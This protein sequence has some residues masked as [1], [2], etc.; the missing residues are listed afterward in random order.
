MASL[1]VPRYPE[2]KFYIVGKGEEKE[3]LLQ[4]ISDYHLENHVFLKGFVEDMPSLY[5]KVSIYL[6]TSRVEGLPMVLLE[7]K[8]FRLPTVSYDILTGPS[9]IILDGVNGYL[10]PPERVDLLAGK[11]CELISN[12]SLYASFSEHAW[13]NIRDFDKD[14][15]LGQWTELLQKLCP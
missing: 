1:I 3:K 11:L 2:W 9:D 5:Q 13:D 12:Q 14:V 15:I 6:M 4:M 10:V 8:Y 7:A